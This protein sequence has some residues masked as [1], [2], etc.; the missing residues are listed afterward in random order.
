MKGQLRD[1]RHVSV[2]MGG[3]GA[4]E[5]RADV[6]LGRRGGADTAGVRPHTAPGSA[7]GL[8]SMPPVE[9]GLWF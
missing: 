3:E 8:A 1:G 4:A 7:G 6:G 9:F 2:C 5:G